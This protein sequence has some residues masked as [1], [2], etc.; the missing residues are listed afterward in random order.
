LIV[1]LAIAMTTPKFRGI[2]GVLSIIV[3][4]ATSLYFAASYFGVL[5]IWHRRYFVAGLPMMVCLVG[6]AVASIGRH[7]WIAAIGLLVGLMWSQ[8]TIRKLQT[9]TRP[10]IVRGEDWKTAIAMIPDGESVAVDAGLIES[11]WLDHLSPD[12]PPISDRQ[13]EY[14]TFVSRG[15]YACTGEVLPVKSDL[16]VTGVDWI[17]CRRPARSID[18]DQFP[19]AVIHARGRVSVI[20]LPSG[21]DDGLK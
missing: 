16:S 3:V 11:V 9:P 19:G 8:G 5:P 20:E 10:L 4:A 14:L 7:G 17:I 6:L 2:A 13:R 12:G 21:M 1:P 18:A 15:P